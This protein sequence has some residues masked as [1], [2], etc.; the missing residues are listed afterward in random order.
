MKLGLIDYNDIFFEDKT[1]EIELK[2]M[3][4]D[5]LMDECNYILHGVKQGNHYDDMFLSYF[6]KGSLSEEERYEAEVL[7]KLAYCNMVIEL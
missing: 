4:D 1:L 2:D 6:K 5:K 7:Y 3:S